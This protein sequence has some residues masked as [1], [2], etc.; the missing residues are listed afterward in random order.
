MIISSHLTEIVME[1][2]AN[3]ILYVYIVYSFYSLIAIL[4]CNTVIL[5]ISG[6]IQKNI[7]GNL[8]W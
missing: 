1:N 2:K 4:V 6:E 7:H 5:H 8:Q 3:D